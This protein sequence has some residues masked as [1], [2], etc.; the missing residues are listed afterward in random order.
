MFL[1]QRC[2]AIKLFPESF[3]RI[4]EGFFN[5]M[6]EKPNLSWGARTMSKLGHYSFHTDTIEVSGV[7]KNADKGLLDMVMYHEMLHKELKF[8]STPGRSHYH[9]PEFRRRE[10]QFAD[11][12]ENERKLKRFLAKCRIKSWFFW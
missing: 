4:N 5:G 1:C 12:E 2:K 10:K 7:F 9:T 11:Y 6:M 8:H 3:D